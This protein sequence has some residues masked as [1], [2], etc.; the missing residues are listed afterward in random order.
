MKSLKTGIYKSFIVITFVLISKSNASELWVNAGIYD[1]TNNVS[2]EFYKYAQSFRVSYDFYQLSQLS[3][4]ITTGFSSS[5]R[6]YNGD[7]YD[8]YLIPVQLSWQYSFLVNNSDI[9][10]FIGSGAGFY[11]KMDHNEIFPKNYYTGTYGYHLFSGLQYRITERLK[12][13]FETRYNILISPALE[14]I[15]SS[16]F[17]ILLGVGIVL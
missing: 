6:P 11:A 5:S 16:G 3:F 13:K 8:M 2:K 14:D 15:N 1:F 12:C 7:D 10:P 9:M 4:S 17:D